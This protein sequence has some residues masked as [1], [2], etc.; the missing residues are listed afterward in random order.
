[1]LWCVSSEC[2]SLFD[3]CSRGCLLGTSHLL[4]V[5]FPPPTEFWFACLPLSPPYKLHCITNMSQYS[6]CL[7]VTRRTIS[8]HVAFANWLV[9]NTPYDSRIGNV[10]CVFFF[11]FQ[12]IIKHEACFR[13][14]GL[15]EQLMPCSSL[16][17]WFCVCCD[18]SQWTPSLV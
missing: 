1:M 6:G 3:G 4:S 17:M 16:H 11:F 18:V 2:W 15:S 12:S 7:P 10:R 8:V 14:S 13:R 5:F 9:L